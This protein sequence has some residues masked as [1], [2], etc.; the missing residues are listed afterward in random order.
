MIKNDAGL[1]YIEHWNSNTTN[2]TIAQHNVSI[3]LVSEE[4]LP[5]IL[6]LDV[7]AC[8][9]V[10]RKKFYLASQNNINIWNTGHL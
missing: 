9:G 5:K 1:V 7:K 2:Y 4:D 3:G 8:C 10:R 6:I